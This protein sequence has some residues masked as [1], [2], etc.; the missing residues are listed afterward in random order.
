MPNK[1]IQMI[2]DAFPEKDFY[3]MY[4]ATEA[5]ARLSYLPPH[6]AREKMGSIGKGIP[7]VTLNVM[8]SDGVPVKPGEVG[9]ITAIGDNIMKGY[10]NDPEI[11]RA[12][13]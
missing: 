7:G 9:E 10:Y 13:V 6:L 1:Y 11:G 8:N 5:T 2:V 12:H 4:G 3:V